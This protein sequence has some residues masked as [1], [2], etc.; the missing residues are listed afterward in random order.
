MGIGPVLEYPSSL[1]AH[2]TDLALSKGIRVDVLAKSEAGESLGQ[3]VFRGRFGRIVG[4]RRHKEDI[5]RM[6]LTFPKNHAFNPL[7]WIPDF[8]LAR[9]VE[10]M[11]QENGARRSPWDF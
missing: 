3:Y 9:R 1:D 4:H 2:I 11:L 8:G 7:F 10:R 6:W 5:C